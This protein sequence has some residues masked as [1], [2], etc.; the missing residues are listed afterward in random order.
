MGILQARRSA[1]RG[2]LDRVVTVKRYTTGRDSHGNPTRTLDF[3]RTVWAKREQAEAAILVTD[4]GN[5][6]EYAPRWIVRWMDGMDLTADNKA[7]EIV[8]GV[9]RDIEA[10]S[11]IGRRRY[12]ELST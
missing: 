1:E 7:F 6:V 12:L 10:V 11:P 4:T 8:D 3:A 9:A 2:Q 5:T